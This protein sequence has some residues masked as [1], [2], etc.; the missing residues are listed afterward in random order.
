MGDNENGEKMDNLQN[1]LFEE[2]PCN[3]EEKPSVPGNYTVFVED[4]IK[5]AAGEGEDLKKAR[6]NI[7]SN[8]A[9][10]TGII[11]SE[12]VAFMYEQNVETLKRDDF[13]SIAFKVTCYS[14]NLENEGFI[15]IELARKLIKEEFDKINPRTLFDF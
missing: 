7:S 2:S 9:R 13:A 8:Q 4:L 1:K 11:M 10:F 5:I 3:A 12:I 14:T 15:D 6:E